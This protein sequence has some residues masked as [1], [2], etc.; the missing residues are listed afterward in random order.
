MNRQTLRDEPPELVGIGTPSSGFLRF[1][2]AAIFLS[3]DRNDYIVS[4]WTEY[5]N[6]FGEYT[7]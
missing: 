6:S 5:C 3:A 1:G 7:K 4:A 2:V